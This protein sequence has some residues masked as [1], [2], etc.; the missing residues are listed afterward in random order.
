M[1]NETSTPFA[2]T[3]DSFGCP[4]L[5]LAAGIFDAGQDP[6]ALAEFL[7]KPGRGPNLDGETIREAL[8]LARDNKKKWDD[9][10]E[11]RNLDHA[12]LIVRLQALWEREG[13]SAHDPKEV[14]A[15]LAVLGHTWDD[16]ALCDRQKRNYL[17]VAQEIPDEAAR[18]GKAGIKL[19]AEI[20]TIPYPSKQC[21]CMLS[22]V[23]QV[24]TAATIRRGIKAV[25]RAFCKGQSE[26]KALGAASK[27]MYG[28][29]GTEGERKLLKV[30][31]KLTRKL[32]RISEV[33]AGSGVARREETQEETASKR[34]HRKYP[35]EASAE[36]GAEQ[37]PRPVPD[38]VPRPGQ[39]PTA[40]PSAAT[41]RPVA[42]D[43]SAKDDPKDFAADAEFDADSMNDEPEDSMEAAAAEA[44]EA[45]VDEAE[46]DEAE[47]D[48]AEA[49]EAGADEAGADE[50][51]A[52][53]VEANADE[54]EPELDA[55]EPESPEP[56][57]PELVRPEP[58]LRPEQLYPYQHF[59]ATSYPFEAYDLTD[60]ERDACEI[61]TL[62]T[63]VIQWTKPVLDLRYDLDRYKNF[64]DRLQL[65]LCRVCEV[66]G[67]A[68][69]RVQP[70]L[71]NL[72]QQGE[73][74]LENLFQQ[75]GKDPAASKTPRYDT[76][77]PPHLIENMPLDIVDEP[78]LP[79]S[80]LTLNVLAPYEE[81][82]PFKEKGTL[83][84]RVFYYLALLKVLRQK[85]L[86]F[87]PRAS[88]SRQAL[89]PALA[90][91]LERALEDLGGYL[92]RVRGL[93]Y[94]EGQRALEQEAEW[95]EEQQQIEE[96]KKLT[97]SRILILGD[98]A[99]SSHYS[100]IGT[101]LCG[102]HV[103]ISMVV[104][105]V[106]I[107]VG[108]QG[109]GKT[110]GAALL[111][112]TLHLPLPGLG[113]VP[114]GKKSIS[115]EVDFNKGS[116]R[117]CSLSGIF[118]SPYP[119]HRQQLKGLFDFEQIVAFPKIDVMVLPGQIDHY[120][121]Q[122]Q[123]VYGEQHER[124]ILHEMGFDPSEM[125]SLFYRLMLPIGTRGNGQAHTQARS[126]LDSIIG[127]MGLGCHPEKLFAEF[128][129][130]KFPG[131][132]Q[133]AFRAQ[134]ELIKK[135][136]RPGEY[137]IDR[138]KGNA[139]LVVL[140]ESRN[141]GPQRL[142]S[143]EVAIMAALSA[144]LRDGSHPLRW[145]F[146]HEL[147]KQALH[148]IIAPYLIERAAEVRHNECSYYLETQQTGFLPRELVA[149]CTGILQCKTTNQLDYQLLQ[150]LF[151]A[152]QGIPFRHIAELRPGSAYM[153]FHQANDPAFRDRAFL[154]HLR[155]TAT[156]AGGETLRML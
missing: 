46:A 75:T 144:I 17:K 48:E 145:F 104:A 59:I 133:A 153:A 76:F 23:M 151:Y 155:A 53:E 83:C 80:Y 69:E 119:E 112:E 66:L 29:S 149:L 33:L 11:S 125:N 10:A 146:M 117:R 31:K 98:D 12:G 130:A 132:N 92:I 85:I 131:V 134:F 25:K 102:R 52:D 74:E 90:Y 41:G 93:C 24:E 81:K 110:Q 62:V 89:Y 65:H 129:K 13:R 16:P 91:Q 140:M 68:A 8:K 105:Q 141:L 122:F 40:A 95:E 5:S 4:V 30:A 114:Q 99:I 78:E 72:A 139:P 135:L 57:E 115:F 38:P 137:M 61:I 1:Q 108:L 26:T 43:D 7:K 71:K 116:T 120:R 103:A 124:L 37:V 86:D 128:I 21:L 32:G 88:D 109:T 154:A 127:N 123:N 147:G 6:L 63:H 79:M 118:P 107:A 34:G 84:V 19:M 49:D 96:Q 60:A 156:W 55:P 152:F 45:E 82:N 3:R 9:S 51:E 42:P 58:A 73:A 143:L 2:V 28:D 70:M 148:E 54:S 138:L 50:A 35:R 106:I 22:T 67:D 15:Y 111:R 56:D 101:I 121:S 136:T 27:A 87:E 36:Q 44:H 113:V 64:E 18:S 77:V 39:R 142:L 14:E 47:A 20:A 94:I 150:Q 100:K 97:Q 126:L